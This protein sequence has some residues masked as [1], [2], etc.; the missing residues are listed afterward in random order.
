MGAGYE[1]KNALAQFLKGRYRRGETAA[2][3]GPEVLPPELL[4]LGQ[5]PD[6]PG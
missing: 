1:K 3:G 6:L 4:C 5:L 2:F